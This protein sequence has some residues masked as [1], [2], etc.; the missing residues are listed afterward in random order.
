VTL[1]RLSAYSEDCNHFLVALFEH[2]VTIIVPLE[3]GEVREDRVREPYGW[4]SIELRT[5]LL[6]RDDEKE[7]ARA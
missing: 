5:C 2:A 1:G 7:M 3:S 6:I 4:D